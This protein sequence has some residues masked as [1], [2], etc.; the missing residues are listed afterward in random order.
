MVPI[1]RIARANK[2]SSSCVP[3]LLPAVGRRQMPAERRLDCPAL[4]GACY[5]PRSARV[6]DHGYGVSN[7]LANSRLRFDVCGS[8]AEAL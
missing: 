5:V 3:T 1:R 7:S 2:V 6:G 4:P 8:G